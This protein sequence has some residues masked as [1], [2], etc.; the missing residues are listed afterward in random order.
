MVG[1]WGSA[2]LAA[3]LTLLAERMLHPGGWWERAPL[4]LAVA[5]LVLWIGPAAPL[6]VILAA[7][8]VAREGLR[9]THTGAVV[10]D[11]PALGWAARLGLVA[12]FTVGL[13]DLARD[14][15]ELL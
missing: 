11:H 12:I 1:G 9:R 15:A 14:T 10:V 6:L 8:W 2:E 7:G 5:P 4:L 13:L 3:L